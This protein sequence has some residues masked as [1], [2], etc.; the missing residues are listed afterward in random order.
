MEK[1]ILLMS[2]FVNLWS[3]VIYPPQ[4]TTQ[5]ENGIKDGE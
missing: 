5:S 4:Y 2:M 3:I 1:I